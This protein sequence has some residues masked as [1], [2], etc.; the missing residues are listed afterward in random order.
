MYLVFQASIVDP[1]TTHYFLGMFL[2][3]PS[4]DRAWIFEMYMNC[5][6]K[7]IIWPFHSSISKHTFELLPVNLE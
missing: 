1:T 2:M 4:L 7:L 6:C 3:Q 5:N